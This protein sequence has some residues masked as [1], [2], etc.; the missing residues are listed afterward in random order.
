MKERMITI[1]A[2]VW[3]VS[4]NASHHFILAGFSIAAVWRVSRQWR[5]WV[6]SGAQDFG[7]DL[8]AAKA[9]AESRALELLGASAPSLTTGD[10]P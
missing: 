3:V 9:W 7:P 4:K 10:R 8:P 5:A 1:P 2:P 6:R